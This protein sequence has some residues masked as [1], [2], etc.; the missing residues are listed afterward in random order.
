MLKSNVKLKEGS[1]DVEKSTNSATAIDVNNI[2]VVYRSYEGRPSTLKESIIRFLKTREHKFYSNFNAL[3][4]VSFKVGRGKVLGVVGSNG[5]GKS[6]LLKVLSG[7]LPPTSGSVK[8][9]GELDSLILLGAGFHPDLN[10]IEN[11][12]LHSSLYKMSRLQTQQRVDSILDFA[13]LHDFAHT[14][15]KY[16]SSGMF[17]RLGFSV[18][19]DRN[20]DVLLVDEVLGVGD[21]RFQ[22]KCFSLFEDYVKSGKTIIFVT[23]SMGT[24]EE[25]ADE[26][27]VLSRGNIIF[28]GNTEQGIALY[29]DGSYETRL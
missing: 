16:Y 6:T 14:P 18:A 27:L 9:N 24:L 11:I 2:T 1:Y 3:S 12:F 13:E 7:V 23:H 15:I 5:A 28:Q 19:V 29:R 26:V 22:K 25:L 4:D 21:E 8:I 17:A 20:P 10:A